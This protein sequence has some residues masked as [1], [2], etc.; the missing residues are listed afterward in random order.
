MDYIY[1]DIGPEDLF[2]DDGVDEIEDAED[3][4]LTD[5]GSDIDD[6]G[7]IDDEIVDSYDY[8][9]NDD[10]EDFT[11]DDSC[12]D[13][14]CDTIDYEIQGTEE[15]IED[16]NDEDDLSVLSDEIYD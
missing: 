11:Y 4:I 14:N 7:K 16:D 9:V 2:M 10:L 15:I 12:V 8:D 5:A 1:D 3:S 6:I 13:D